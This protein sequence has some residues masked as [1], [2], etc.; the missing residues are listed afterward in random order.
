M[1]Q[2]LGQHFL[3]NK[4]KIQI[5]FDA[6]ELAPGDT[7]IE[8]GPGKGALTHEL[9]QRVKDK[10]VRLIGIE[11]DP[12]LASALAENLSC[13][14]IDPSCFQLSTSNS[15]AIIVGDALCVLPS[16][17]H[18]PQ[19]IT[20]NSPWK[21]VGNIPYYITG[22]L[23][24]VLGELRY[25]PAV[26]VLMVQR[27]VAERVCA[28]PPRMNILAASVQRWAYAEIVDFVS[29]RDFRPQPK[30]DSAVIRLRTKDKGLRTKEDERYYA[31]VKALFRQPRK[32]I[33]NNLSLLNQFR[34]RKDELKRLLA[35]ASV[36]PSA[37][38]QNLSVLEITK[39][40]HVL[41]NGSE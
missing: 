2:K 32:T 3:V 14:I 16:L 28:L 4:E 31:I 18:D 21:L 36:H 35:C 10:G 9:R 39:L 25:K 6:L 30:V 5:I 15:C 8:I 12:K 1:G 23:F 17:V 34:G 37:R 24:R 38:A 19:L 13:P 26:A 29:R 27:E 40:A 33:F 20:H 11:K 7:V 22:R 41:Y